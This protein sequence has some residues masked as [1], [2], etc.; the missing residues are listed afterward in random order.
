M[1][2]KDYSSIAL[3]IQFLPRPQVYTYTRIHAALVMSN[4]FALDM[5]CSCTSSWICISCYLERLIF[6]NLP[7]KFLLWDT[8]Q[9]SPPSEKLPIR[10]RHSLGPLVSAFETPEFPSIITQ[11]SLSYYLHVSH[12]MLRVTRRAQI[13]Q[14][15]CI[16]IIW[17]LGF[18]E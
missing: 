7:H 8:I 18:I 15:L 9:E 5:T 16:F 4:C 10:L 6:L 3:W 11:T 12:K 1:T 13:L 14:F 2:F 17:W